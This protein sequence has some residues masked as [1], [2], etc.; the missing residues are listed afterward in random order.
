MAVSLAKGQKV[1]LEEVLG[2]WA[3]LRG[4]GKGGYLTEMKNILRKA[5][6]DKSMTD[7]ELEHVRV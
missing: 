2:Y 1:D 3:E 6:G 7:E 4:D 5:T